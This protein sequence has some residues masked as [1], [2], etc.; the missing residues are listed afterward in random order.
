G[1]KKNFPRSKGNNDLTDLK[2]SLYQLKERFPSKSEATILAEE[3]VDYD[4]L[5]QV[6]D[7]IRLREVK[8][9]GRVKL[10][11]LFPGISI[12]D[13]PGIKK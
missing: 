5:V 7:A 11:N 8:E 10:A 13:A 4:I 2:N 9:N 3:N 6:M 1:L 12:G